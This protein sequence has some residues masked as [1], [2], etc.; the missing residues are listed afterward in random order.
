MSAV[1]L[2][3]LLIA[4]AGVVVAVVC[5]LAG[6]L[7][8]SA[9]K[10]KDP[11][12]GSTLVWA[13]HVGAIVA[14]AAL[15]FCCLLM[16]YCFV[17]GDTSIEYVVKGTSHNEGPLGTFYRIAGLW[18]GREGSLMF[19]GWLIAVFALMMT[20]R[21]MRKLE[22]LDSV[23]LIVM[24][25]VLAG[26]LGIMLFSEDNSPFV[27]MDPKYFDA[28]GNLTGAAALWGMNAL[29]EHWAMA[30]HPPALF[31]GYAGMTV[32]F[33]YAIATL[34][35]NDTSDAW[36]RRSQRY[37]MFAWWFLGIGIGLGAVWA[38]VVLGWGGYWGWDAVENASLLPWLVGLALIHSMTVYRQRGAFKRWSIM[39][40]ALAFAFVITGTF[41]ARSGLIE[42]VHAFTGDPVSLYLFGVLIVLSL[43]VAAGGVITRWKSFAPVNASDEELGSLMSRDA[44]YYFNNVIMV[45]F[46]FLVCYLTVSSALPSWLP[47]GG[48]A[49]SAGTYNAVARPLGVLYCLVLAVC[50]L[51]SWAITTR[52][53]FLKRAKIPAILAGILFVA[54]MVYLVTTLWPVYDA[55]IAAGGTKAEGLASE[56]PA[57]YYKG[58][59]A[60]GFAVA[61]LVIFNSLYMMGRRASAWGKAHGVSTPVALFKMI[62]G[63]VSTVGGYIAHV[64]IGVILIG[65]IG[66]SMFVTERSGY[67][68]YEAT[69]DTAAPFTAGG[70]TLRYTSNSIVDE[71][72]NIHYTV[73]F[74]VYRGDQ[75]V[76][77]VAPSMEMVKETQQ[78]KS[79]AGIISMPTHDVFV[80]YKGVNSIGHFSMDVRINPLIGLVWAGFGLLMLGV[81]I[82]ALGRRAP[83]GDDD[84][85]LPEP[86]DDE[87][88]P[89]PNDDDAHQEPEASVASQ[90]GDAVPSEPA[91]DVSAE[92]EAA[93]HESAR[94]GEPATERS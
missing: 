54:L 74:D 78:T 1:G 19:W 70:Y 2:I 47:F 31:I 15:T 72:R 20:V 63:H 43:V 3:G 7:S 64:G 17:T 13:G 94:D 45:V 90:V 5:L 38:Y 69:S 46:A 23:A 52:S 55:T 49:L 30:V 56:G 40:A 12:K 14:F 11:D 75:Y 86:N 27:A 91:P 4:F 44:A 88:L 81:A 33:A 51:L 25:V 77:H 85:A 60:V 10:T 26:F 28:N 93:D 66:S 24:M 71:G 8:S 21:N 34:V 82:A 65:L 68:E 42:S 50:P 76:G 79:N 89:E 62:P 57:W 39:C 37:T 36:V 9:A 16:V 41:I 67:I 59:A 53:Q 35:I 83:K 80:V 58:L 22:R 61:S 73:E 48:T 29:L 32:P 84:E 87:A 18:E 92:R 6:L